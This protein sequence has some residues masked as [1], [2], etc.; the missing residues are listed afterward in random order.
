MQKQNRRLGPASR[1]AIHVGLG[2]MI[3]LLSAGLGW[4]QA[5]K[6]PGL[7]Q[8]FPMPDYFRNNIFGRNFVP[9][10]K[11]HVSN[12][13]ERLTQDGKVAIS[14]QDVVAVAL[15]NNL[16]IEV[17]RQFYPAAQYDVLKSMAPFDP[18]LKASAGFD[19][20]NQPSS[21]FLQTGIFGAVTSV[22][23]MSQTYNASYLQNFLT[24]T[25]TE[26]DYFN[27][28]SFVG[29]RLASLNPSFT[30]QMKFSFL[31]PLLKNRGIGV[32]SEPIKV[33]KNTLGMTKE[34]FRQQVIS[35]VNQALN[36][37]WELVFDREDV[38]VKQA[39]LDLA[40]KTNE[41]NKR[42]VEIGTL[43]PID[44]VQS[45]TAVA[46]RR[47]DLITSQYTLQQTQDNLKRFLSGKLDPGAIIAKLDP[48][49]QA[50]PP[51][52]QSIAE[53]PDSIRI[54]LNNRPEVAQAHL[55]LKNRDLRV[56][57]TKNQL[58]PE[59]DLTGSYSWTGLAG[60]SVV[61]DANGNP[62]FNPDGTREVIESGFRNATHQLFSFQFPEYAFGVN[63]TLPLKN[64]SAEADFGRASY[65]QRQSASNVRLTEQQVALQVRNAITVLQMSKQLTEAAT[66]TRELQEKT[67]DAE[68]KKYQLG[69]STIRFVLQEQTN[70]AIDQSAEVRAVVNWIKSKISL[71]TATGRLLNAYSVQ[72]DDVLAGN[73][74]AGKNPRATLTGAS[75]ASGAAH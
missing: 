13:I 8:T 40:T 34:A 3:I 49:D 5:G 73:E 14:D 28:K 67:L 63:I 60:N 6:D 36:L 12:L 58:L 69:A 52:D 44:V 42:Q 48:V 29:S 51:A 26:I 72:I 27:S 15:Q 23:R 75:L 70:L 45:E 31:Q 56:A 4:G 33:A 59:V 47:Q 57:F 50:K 25:A 9:P 1:T 35:I 65:E 32:N 61:V 38:R 17:Q 37:Y 68:N 20:A 74:P 43:A 24:G 64:R 54:A 66:R 71:E 39:S 18:I 53:V 11:D 21:S 10:Q 41:D 19:R 46:S 30:T 16:D 7:K 2:L 22:P 62:V 55:D